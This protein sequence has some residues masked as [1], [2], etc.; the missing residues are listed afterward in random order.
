M[1]S[2]QGLS[3]SWCQGYLVS[4]MEESMKKD[5]G[6]PLGSPWL[7]LGAEGRQILTKQHKVFVFFSG[8]TSPTGGLDGH[9]NASCIGLCREQ[10]VLGKGAVHTDD[11]H[12]SEGPRP[13]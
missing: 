5:L 13:P 6:S 3:Q 12:P 10:A 1:E 8:Q 4:R 7:L 2:H 11:T 9:R